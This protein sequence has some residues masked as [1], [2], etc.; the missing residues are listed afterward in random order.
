MELKL[1]AVTDYLDGKGSYETIAAELQTGSI[2]P[3]DP[4]KQYCKG[5][6]LDLELM[7]RNAE[8]KVI[9]GRIIAP[10]EKDLT[11]ERFSDIDSYYPPGKMP[12]N[13]AL[14]G[15]VEEDRKKQIA[16]DLKTVRERLKNIR[17]IDALDERFQR[18][19]FRRQKPLERIPRIISPETGQEIERFQNRFRWGN[20]NGSFFALPNDYNFVGKTGIEYNIVALNSLH[21]LLRSCNIQMTVLLIPDAWQ[22][23][24]RALVP[25][26]S[27]IGDLTSLQ[28]A[29]TLL[30]YGIEA[31]Y[32][33]DTVLAGI[34]ASE[35]LFCY[36][37]SRPEADLWKILADTAARR[38]ARF[39]GNAF[40]ETSASHFAERRG[41]TVFGNHYRWPDEVNC[42]EHKNGETVE[43][44]EVFRN[45]APFRPDPDS[46]ILVI[47]GDELNLPGPGHTFSG[48]LSLRLKY[49]VD[50]L[51]L[52]GEVWFHNLAAVLSR[53]SIRFLAGKQV[54]LLMLSPRML[55]E[56]VFPDIQELSAL[57]GRLRGKKPVHRFAVK[58]ASGDF[59]P[60]APVRGERFYQ[61]K[62]KWNSIWNR[63]GRSNPP[64]AAVRIENS[65]QEQPLM[66]RE[67]PENKS[68][69][70]YILTV[71]TAC[72]PGQAN[73]LS[74]NGRKIPLPIN[75][76][77]PHFRPSAV[78]L[79]L[80]AKSVELK[81]S[82]K[83][84]NLIL[85]RE[86]LLYQ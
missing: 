40:Q 28:C 86:I 69:R 61:S 3:D 34:P 30:E 63:F 11:C 42:G 48:Q 66:K 13:A 10:P 56:Y 6:W 47:G 76:A 75:S 5:E 32:P 64:T 52:R 17:R 83:Q 24:A 77:E 59:P 57:H 26:I 79:P 51:T 22:I 78:E 60:P 70:P 9:C 72:Y 39:G 35:R 82:G 67:L 80:N 45:G 20:R 71:E 81:I 46:R 44:V 15:A 14:P 53:N 74:V 58:T 41:K 12:R 21:N 37:D 8:W 19:W 68:N 1:Q 4:V 65:G 36:P 43:S 54:C 16:A 27:R 25:E 33:D 23:A 73:I 49:P 38:L 29:A 85:I 18:A 55:T 7:K 2:P 84:D 62:R 31:I 50:E